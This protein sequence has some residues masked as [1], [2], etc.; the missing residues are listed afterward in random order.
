VLTIA[1]SFPIVRRVRRGGADV[2]RGRRRMTARGRIVDRIGARDGELL[3]VC[4]HFA[5]LRAGEADLVGCLPIGDAN[6]ATLALASAFPDDPEVYA[7]IFAADPFRPAPFLLAALR[8]AGVRSVVNLPTVAMAADGLAQ[9]LSHAG[10]DYAAELATLAKATALGLRVLAVATTV[11]QGRQA[12][13][14]GIGRLLF[15]PAADGDPTAR[16]RRAAAAVEAVR[17][18]RATAPSAV[19]L[20]FRHPDYGDELEPLIAAADGVVEWAIAPRAKTTAP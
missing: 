20:A 19:I 18:M 14:A 7:G 15:Y 16:R 1:V 11:E 4:P 2:A 3:L 13:A 8:E 5:G 12:T 10:V 9:A 6:G 17:T